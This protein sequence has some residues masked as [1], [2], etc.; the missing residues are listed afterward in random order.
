MHRNA[1]E[2]TPLVVRTVN[3]Q[4]VPRLL[5]VG[6]GSGAYSI[7]FAQSNADL[8]AEILD[9]PA[10][11]GDLRKDP[12]GPDYDL[13]F[14]SAICHMLS[15]AEN[16][17]LLQRCHQALAPDG[18]IVIQD[19]LLQPDKTAP[20]FAALFSLNMLVGTPGGASCSE[21][22]YAAWLGEAGFRE[23]RRE[24][25]PGPTALMIASKS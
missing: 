13:V 17:D 16:L 8:H 20:R 15:P 19:F 21:P 24:S 12:L 7:A 11:L 18:R 25:L 22:E 14:L 6:G 4:N 23:I 10:V 2:R 5:D 9:L 3:S 1:A